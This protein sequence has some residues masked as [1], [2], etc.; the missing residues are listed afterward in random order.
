MASENSRMES[1]VWFDLRSEVFGQISMP[2]SLGFGYEIKRELMVL[3]ESLSVIVYSKC[4]HMDRGFEIWVM[5]EYGVEDSW[6]K[7]FSV[8]PF[9]YEVEA[10][11]SWKNGG[12]VFRYQNWWSDKLIVYDPSTQTTTYFRVFTGVNR[13]FTYGESL[14][15]VE[16]CKKRCSQ[17]Y[18]ADRYSRILFFSLFLHT[19]YEAQ[20]Q[21]WVCVD[22]AIQKIFNLL[23]IN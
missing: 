6:T 3:K 18:K 11:G 17:T 15:T 5:T 21:L 12:I 1:I 2:D 22:V 10:L 9:S 4:G 14:E 19:L 23:G 8:V 20:R 13:A 16:G 7:R